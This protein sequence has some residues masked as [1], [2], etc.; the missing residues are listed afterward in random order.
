MSLIRILYKYQLDTVVYKTTLEMVT[1]I[2]LSQ[3][4]LEM[5]TNHAVPR[6]SALEGVPLVYTQL[7]LQFIYTHNH[8]YNAGVYHYYQDV[9]SEYYLTLSFL[10]LNLS[11]TWSR[12]KTLES[13]T[14]LTSTPSQRDLR[15]VV[16]YW[17]ATANT[18]ITSSRLIASVSREPL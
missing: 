10:V 7:S 12:K 2:M 5:V 13:S 16:S 14:L 1:I 4:T 17:S 9:C 15:L 11:A 8:V 18:S 3:T 6:L